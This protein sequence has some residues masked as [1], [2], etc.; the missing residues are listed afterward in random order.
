MTSTPRSDADNKRKLD[1][2]VPV[3][4]GLR[5][6]QIRAEADKERADQDVN[7][8]RDE[9]KQ[10]F[11]TDDPASIDKYIADERAG[12]TADIDEFEARLSDI[13]E[14]LAAVEGPAR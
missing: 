9:A 14:R 3:Y 6:Q 2:L 10:F 11:G 1:Q 8:S 4:D 7:A 13:R 12:N 5:S